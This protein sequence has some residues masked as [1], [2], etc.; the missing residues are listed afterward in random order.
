MIYAYKHF[1]QVWLSLSI[2]M[3]ECIYVSDLVITLLLFCS[4]VAEEEEY[5]ELPEE[6]VTFLLSSEYVHIKSEYQ[7]FVSAMK[8]ILHDLKAR[9]KCV[10]NVCAPIRFPIISYQQLEQFIESCSD[11]SLQI[12]LKKLVID[13]KAASSTQSMRSQLKLKLE[14]YMFKPREF[15]RKSIYVSGGYCQQGQRWGE[16]VSLAGVLCYSSFEETWSSEAELHQSRSSHGACVLD[17]RIYVIGGES[18][19]LIFDSME[20]YDPLINRWELMP[21]LTK[22]RSGLGVCSLHGSIYAIGG[23]I[24]SQIGATVEKFDPNWNFWRQWDKMPNSRYAMGVVD[25]EGM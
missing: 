4:Q 7:V 25:H 9:R 18:D 19:S 13:Y 20:M 8:W 10:F 22:P 23:W 11:L 2:C 6:N 3:K 5:L 17:G 21:S 1:L 16:S 24:G 12:A 15:A 14:P